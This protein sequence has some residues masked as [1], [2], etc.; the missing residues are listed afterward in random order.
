MRKFVIVFLF[1]IVLGSCSDEP[2]IPVDYENLLGEW[3]SYKYCHTYVTYD[4]GTTYHFEYFSQDSIPYI[5]SLII[6]P[7]HLQVNF[8]NTN[9]V[10]ECF[11]EYHFGYDNVTDK[12]LCSFRKNGQ[13]QF[14]FYYY[15]V[16]NE[17]KL[18]RESFP[19]SDEYFL[20]TSSIYLRKLN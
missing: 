20:N 1:S 10:D 8:D 9:V 6:E 19:F 13:S 12:S 7:G 11:D 4:H 2:V 3:E 5:V 16:S 14:H 15:H 18:K 17:I